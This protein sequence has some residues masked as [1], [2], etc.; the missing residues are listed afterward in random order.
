MSVFDYSKPHTDNTVVGYYG[1]DK[2]IVKQDDGAL[3]Y[4]EIPNNLIMLGETIAP[5]DLTS[6]AKLPPEQQ[7]EVK[8]LYAD[9]EV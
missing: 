7:E 6:I 2:V 1:D 3:F 9:C 8:K 5:R 4:C